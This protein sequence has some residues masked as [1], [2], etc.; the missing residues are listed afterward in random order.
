MAFHILVASYTNDIVTLTFDPTKSSLEKTSSLTVGRHPS[1][2]S[3]HPSH[4]SVVWTGLEQANGKI[5]AL[6]HEA[7]GKLSLLSEVSSAGNDPCSLLIT[8]NEILVANYS[9]GNIASIPIFKDH[10]PKDTVPT[11]IQLHGTGP[12]K[13]RQEGSH[14]HQVILH[15]EYQELFVPDL[16]ADAVRRFKKAEDGSWKFAGHIGI[17]LGGG[18]RHVAFYNGDLFTILE[19]GSKVVRHKLPPLPSPPKL[20][21]SVPTMSQPLPTPNEMLGAEI[22]IPK[23][24][25]SFPTPYIYLSN[26]N[27]PSP[28]GDIISIFA[29][30]EPDSLELIAEVRSGLKHLRGMVFGGQDDK[31]LIAGGGRGGGVKVF[32]R[33]NGGKGLKE[34]ASN[35][36]VEA[37]TGFLWL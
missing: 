19:L 18:P 24:N 5:L 15:E 34:V 17:E 16:G 9:S 11:S 8:E 21:K 6:S 10:P 29:I 25:V 35:D 28:E 23:T 32:E 36:S 33:I 13:S 31:F 37:P 14:P 2:I 3:S 30:E 20:I 27:D 4:P 22:L 26:R 12:N 7:D 1:W